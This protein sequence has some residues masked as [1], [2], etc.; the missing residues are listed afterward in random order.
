MQTFD[1]Q[2]VRIG[3]AAAFVFGFI[4]DPGNLPKWT[5]A[6]RRADATSAE[7]ATPEGAIEI[8]LTTTA[9]GR[10][11]TIDWTL[12]FPDGTTGRAYSRVT[13]EG[14]GCV[15]SFVLT[16]P[17]GALARLEGTLREQKAVLAQELAT[18]K[19]LLET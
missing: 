13:P 2:A 10:S 7:L 4:A 16:A 3:R 8:G 9:D 14:E 6:F 17:P 15:Y 18:L 12:S 5:R 1:V 11:G 19:D